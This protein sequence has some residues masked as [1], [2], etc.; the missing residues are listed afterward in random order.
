MSPLLTDM[1]GGTPSNLAISVMNGPAVEVVAGI[2]LPMLVKLARL[3]AELPLPEAVLQAQE[4]GPQIHQH[5][6]QGVVRTMITRPAIPAAP[7]QPP[8]AAAGRLSSIPGPSVGARVAARATLR[9]RCSRSRRRCGVSEWRR[10]WRAERGALRAEPGA[11]AGRGVLV[12]VLPIINNKGLHARASAKF[13]QTV[14]RFKSDVTRIALRRDGR[15]PLHH[16]PDDARRG[17]R[18][19]VTVTAKGPDAEAC[20]DAIEALLADKFGEES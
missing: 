6:Q 5:R 17:P 4:A 7:A 11:Q 10:C 3:R 8:S 18:H 20:M 2:N 19:D 15:R 16:G 13:V 9:Y 1:F 14:E 12:R